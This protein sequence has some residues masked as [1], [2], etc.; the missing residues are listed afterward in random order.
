MRAAGG[1]EEAKITGFDKALGRAQLET[2]AEH[3]HLDAGFS[4]DMRDLEIRGAGELLG[5]HQ[6]GQIAAAGFHLYTRLLAEAARRLRIGERPQAQ[7]DAE[8]EGDSPRQPLS[9]FQPQSVLRS[10]LSI[11]L[12]IPISI[13]ADYVPDKNVHLLLYRRIAD[14]T[15]LADRPP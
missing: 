11:E 9:I 12:P 5:T 15:T 2:I 13:R 10:Q 3:T 8:K 1:A 14:L 6:H 7:T 4:I